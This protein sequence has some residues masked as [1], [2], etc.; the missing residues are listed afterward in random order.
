VIGK[1]SRGGLGFYTAEVDPVQGAPHRKQLGTM[2]G[3]LERHRRLSPGVGW[4]ASVAG[5]FGR[6]GGGFS[7][8]TVSFKLGPVACMLEGA[9]Q[10]WRCVGRVTPCRFG[11]G[12]AQ[13]LMHACQ[14]AAHALGAPGG[15]MVSGSHGR[16]AVH[17]R[18]GAGASHGTGRWG[19]GEASGKVTA[20]EGVGA[21]LPKFGIHS[22]HGDALGRRG[23][24][25]SGLCKVGSD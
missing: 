18:S 5:R 16:G 9:G 19:D 17:G 15:S 12:E 24:T 4:V 6:S 2:G 8:A 20:R 23:V 10:W 21:V 14:N 13:G 1:A 3:S 22:G 7:R 25:G 11:C